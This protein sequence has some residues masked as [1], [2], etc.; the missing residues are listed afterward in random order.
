MNVLVLMAGKGQRFINEGYTV[1]KPL[2]QV[3]HKPIVQWTTESCPYIKHGGEEQTTNVHLYFAVL[4]EHLKYGLDE[5]LFKTYGKNITII[6]F[7]TI[8]SGSLETAVLAAKRMWHKSDNLLVL[9]ADNKYDDNGLEDFI[10]KIAFTSKSAAVA[11]WDNA[12]KSLPNKWSNVIIENGLAKNIKEKDDSWTHHPTLI[13][14]FYFSETQ[15]F[16]DTARYVLNNL[17]PVDFNGNAEYYMSMVPMHMINS[18][19]PVYVHKVTNVVPLGTPRDL[20]I[21][22]EQL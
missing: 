18:K 5:L 11:C 9:D 4:R 1:P 6:P 12:D 3:N 17:D 13:G 22:K 14:I 19:L 20:E 7:D 15:F 10:R 16:I 8:T 2:I 21:F